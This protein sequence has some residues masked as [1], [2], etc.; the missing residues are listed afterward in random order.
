VIE[1]LIGRCKI[2]MLTLDVCEVKDKQMA[3]DHAVNHC[4]GLSLE[5]FVN[6]VTVVVKISDRKWKDSM[7]ESGTL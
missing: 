1:I 4:R 2:S 5:I 3:G 6:L 7:E